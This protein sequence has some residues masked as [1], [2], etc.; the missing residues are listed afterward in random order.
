MRWWGWVCMMC[1]LSK[2]FSTEPGVFR[3]HRFLLP[4]GRLLHFEPHFAER[5]VDVGVW[6]ENVFLQSLRVKTCRA[7]YEMVLRVSLSLCVSQVLRVSLSL[8]V[9]LVS[10]TCNPSVHERSHPS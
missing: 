5:D 8:R 6:S 9:S 1:E 3:T 4:S 2:H 10:V 7:E